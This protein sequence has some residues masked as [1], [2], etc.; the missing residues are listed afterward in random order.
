MFIRYV[1]HIRPMVCKLNQK[2]LYSK[3]NI[4]IAHP[5]RCPN[6]WGY[7]SMEPIFRW[8]ETRNMKRQYEEMWRGV[9]R[10]MY[11]RKC[12]AHYVRPREADAMS[13]TEVSVVGN[14]IYIFRMLSMGYYYSVRYG[15]RTLWDWTLLGSQGLYYQKDMTG[16]F[17]SGQYADF[18]FLNT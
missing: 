14:F 5:W 15:G 2:A 8:R 13:R 11:P 12:E 16:K 6:R 7:H 18:R 1:K 9:E 4:P 17:S 3:W 10:M